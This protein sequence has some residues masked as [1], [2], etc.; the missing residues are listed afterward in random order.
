VNNFNKDKIN[1]TVVGLGY[2]GLPLA[3]LLAKKFNVTGLDISDNRISDLSKN[4]DHT[5]E[6]TTKDLSS[7]TATFT[8]DP[9]CIKDSNFII[10]TV[11]TPIDN[12]KNPDL[13][14]VIKAT[15]MI[16][17][18]LQNDSIVVY[19]S[20]VYPGVTEDICAPILEKHSSLEWK[21]GFSLGYSPERV[22]PGDKTHTIDKIIKVVSGDTPSTTEIVKYVYDSIVTAG[23]HVAP[24]IKTAEAAKV[25]EN[26]QRDLNIA[27]MNELSIIF[28][29]MDINTKDV[30]RAA[31][32]KW[33]FLKFYPGLVGGHCIGV[34]PYYLTFKAK[35]LGYNP[36]VILSGRNIN[37]NMG[38]Y[39]ANQT[40]KSIIKSGK[41]INDG[42]ILICGFSF[43]ENVP[44]LRNTRVIDI[45]NELQDYNLDVD[46]YDPMIDKTELKAEYG[47]N[48]VNS[49]SDTKYLAVIIA[50]KH[51]DF[52]DIITAD[53]L[54]EIQTGAPIVMDIKGFINN[55]HKEFQDGHYFTL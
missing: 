46:I 44:D 54:K 34:D 30:L 5:N 23:V 1:I 3:I 13:T 37:D 10:V 11:P 52:L 51:N 42:K 20:T 22:N 32:T 14:P 35:E 50:V 36:Q 45:Y 25:I 6:V 28:N 39:I 18:F 49:I 21:K 27:L 4:H 31:E 38:S 2:V 29:K 47:L 16:G 12:N 17:N 7:S 33:N 43:K 55:G 15:E 24:S 53:K 41:N 8:T 19:E 9:T 40:I 26:T 48:A